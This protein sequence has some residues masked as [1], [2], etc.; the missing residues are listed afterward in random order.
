MYKEYA[1]EYI[2]KNVL[3][4]TNFLYEKLIHHI[5]FTYIFTGYIKTDYE[6]FQCFGDFYQAVKNRKNQ[7]IELCF[8]NTK[9]LDPNL[10]AVLS[11]ILKELEINNQLRFIIHKESSQRELLAIGKNGFA[12]YINTKTGFSTKKIDENFVPN[13]RFDPLDADDFVNYIENVFLGHAHIN[14][15]SQPNKETV[16]RHY[17]EIFGNVS[18]HADK[19]T[20][21]FV[22]GDFMN[23]KKELRFTIVDLGVG[24]LSNIKKFTAG[25]VQEPAKAIQWL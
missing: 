4:E 10:C 3:E 1:Y 6:G 18:T 12:E 15:L 17:F 2:E 5:D 21:V 7:V 9:W 14:F 20:S 13:A 24:F 16:K 11:A 8:R 23:S 25:E 19:E 22:C